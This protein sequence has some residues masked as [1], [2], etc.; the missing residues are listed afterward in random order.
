MPRPIAAAAKP[1]Q[2]NGA[3]AEPRIAGL[4]FN[5]LSAFIKSF[6]AQEKLRIVIPNLARQNNKSSKKI[7]IF[8]KSFF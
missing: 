1:L 5:D 3:K 2:S 8:L 7:N 4:V 6:A